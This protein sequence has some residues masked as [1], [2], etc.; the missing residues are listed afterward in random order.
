MKAAT[1]KI[2]QVGEI[3][4]RNSKRPMSEVGHRLNRRGYE[5]EKMVHGMSGQE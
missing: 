5:M 1:R 4:S 2:A 3:G